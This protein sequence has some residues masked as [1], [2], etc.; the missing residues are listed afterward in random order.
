MKS[1][2]KKFKRFLQAWFSPHFYEKSECGT[3]EH[4]FKH[5]SNCGVQVAPNPKYDIDVCWSCNRLLHKRI[6]I[7]GSDV[8]TNGV[9]YEGKSKS[10]KYYI[11]RNN[12]HHHQIEWSW[13][14]SIMLV[15][16]AYFALFDIDFHHFAFVLNSDIDSAMEHIN[17]FNE[18][19][20]TV[21]IYT[22]TTVAGHITVLSVYMMF[23]LHACDSRVNWIIV[24]S[25]MAGIPA[26]IAGIIVTTLTASNSA[27]IPRLQS[28]EF[29]GMLTRH[30]AQEYVHHKMLKEA[31]GLYSNGNYGKLSSV[32]KRNMEFFSSQDSNDLAN[33]WS[34]Q[35]RRVAKIAISEDIANVSFFKD[36]TYPV[37]SLAELAEIYAKQLK[38]MRSNEMWQHC[39]DNPYG[40]MTPYLMSQDYAQGLRDICKNVAYW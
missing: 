29:T 40:I 30:E 33:A 28:D 34:A 11:L 8:A 25:A 31:D 7:E 9:W 12:L 22:A 2:I 36:T 1:I 17:G 16:L 27:I 4:D 35:I 13:V 23:W 3:A 21:S 5:C 32:M 37:F 15:P 24:Y 6:F 26:F 20:K 19:I 18:Y 39:M 38:E 14:L 10:R